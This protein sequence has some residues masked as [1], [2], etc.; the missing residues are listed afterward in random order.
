MA[1]TEVSTYQYCTGDELEALHKY[2]YLSVDARYTEAAVMEEV[3]QAERWVNEY[4][5]QTFT[6]GAAPDGVEFATLEM[7][8]YFMN[9]Q[10]LTDGYLEELPKTLNEILQLCK[11]V[12][13]KNK[14]FIDY[15]S[16]TSDFDLRNRIG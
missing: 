14:I 11:N 13:A 7:A 16:S 3:T 5:G 6:A 1:Y 12:L 4:C 9:R 8:R 10:F 2:T 15:N